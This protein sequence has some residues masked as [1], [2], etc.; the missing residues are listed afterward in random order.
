MQTSESK[1]Q[2]V[3]SPSTTS[4]DRVHDAFHIANLSRH[5]T[6]DGPLTGEV[7]HLDGGT[8]FGK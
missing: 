8:H 7:P 4:I 5:L 2:A 3:P 6:E 1:A